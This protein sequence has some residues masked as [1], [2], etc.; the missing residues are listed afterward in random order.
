MEAFRWDA[1]FITG[2]GEVDAQHHGLVDLINRLGD[3]VTSDLGWS[4]ADIESVFDELARYA[5]KHFTDEEALMLAHG[6]D[7]RFVEPHHQAH[8]TFIEEVTAMHASLA[9]DG[10]HAASG[11]LRFLSH[12]L[13]WHIL[14]Q[15][16]LMARQ[17]A[18]IDAGETPE[19][20]YLSVERPT[21]P[22]TSALLHAL[23]GLFHQVSERNRAL[24]QLNRTLEARVAE[25]THALSEANQRLED[26]AMTDVLTGL[27]NRRQAMSRIEREWLTSEAG[28]APLSCLMV[29]ADAFKAINDAYGHD[30]GDTVLRA[31]A[32]ALVHAVRTDDVVCRLGGDE[33]L[34]VC[35]RTPLEGA[36]Q[37]AES[38]RR[39]VSALRVPA[40]EGTWRGSVSVG[41]A[42]RDSAMTTAEE[43]IRAADQGVY[44]A[45][46]RGRNR[47]ATVQRD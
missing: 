28:D 47:V 26:L 33:F 41:V 3:A 24:S 14:G 18:A 15:D 45:K 4:A 30:A 20:A 43:L 31:L 34:V 39:E 44:L 8:V 5:M 35:P 10:P 36:M 12:W 7:R 2:V 32:R 17:F 29:D 21:D 38:L 13:A 19:Q 1:C 40:G 42:S 9:T 25:R 11:L 22:A 37:V 23:D 16:Q 46:E 6:L 27:P